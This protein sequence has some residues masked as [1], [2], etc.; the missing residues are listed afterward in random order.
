MFLEVENLS[1]SIDGKTI[2]SDITFSSGKGT[3]TLIAGMN[4]SGKSMLLKCLKG[5]EK[6]SSGTIRLDGRELR[7]RK[8][9]MK[10]F[11]L[12]FQDTSLE[13]V[14]STVEKDI[15]F[16]PENLGWD[17][18][19]ISAKVNLM[20]DLFSLTGHRDVRPQV[21]SGGE[22]RKLAIAGVLAME[23]EVLLLDEPFA[24]LDYP[25]TLK[26]IQT[27]DKLH[28]EGA[29][30]LIVSHEA[31]KFLRH[32]DFTIILEKG[33]V[34]EHGRSRDMLPKLPEHN[35]YVPRDAVFEEMSWL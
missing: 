3:T 14:G 35:I 23:P 27:L 11:A 29:T 16:G 8:D 7:R 21:L 19:A 31:E 30:I 28:E 32:T 1:F 2:L 13:I 17:R 24:N 15:A 5:L 20:L 10:A 22:A 4:G 9:R 18:Q 33:R 12:V 26:V 25:S 6:P 34:A